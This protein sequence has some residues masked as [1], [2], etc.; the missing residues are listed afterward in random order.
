MDLSVKPIDT[1]IGEV[2]KK[3]VSTPNTW[4]RA[5]LKKKR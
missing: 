5:Q 2:P 4:K 3:R 1:T